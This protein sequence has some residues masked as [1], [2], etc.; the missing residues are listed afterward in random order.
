M[1][2]TIFYI[3]GYAPQENESF[4]L[5]TSAL[6]KTFTEL[7]YNGNPK[8]ED[9][10]SSFFYKKLKPNKIKPY[11]TS[12][13]LSELINRYLRFHYEQFKEINNKKSLKFKEYRNEEDYIEKLNAII[14]IVKDDILPEF[15]RL[16]DNF[17]NL[18]VDS[19]LS[20]DI[21]YDFNDKII[22]E[23]CVAN[24]LTLV[25]DDY[26]FALIFPRPKILTANSKLVLF[27]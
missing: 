5:D 27:K 11:I 8:S 1:S 18:S 12:I 3:R 14:S 2:K 17:M 15:N 16:N 10:Y 24:K 19:L 25:T 21:T 13:I 7:N 6:I 22:A 23:T 4:L 26:D 20:I 9:Y